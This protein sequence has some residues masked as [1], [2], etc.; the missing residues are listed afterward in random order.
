[1][2]TVRSSSLPIF[3]DMVGFMIKAYVVE[4]PTYDDTPDD[5]APGA[6]YHVLDFGEW[7]I[8]D[9]IHPESFYTEVDPQNLPCWFIQHHGTLPS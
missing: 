8:G 3:S 7:L 1:M 5:G 2:H 9:G 6:V 4:V